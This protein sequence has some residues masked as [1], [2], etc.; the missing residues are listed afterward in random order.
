MRRLY[1]KG[2]RNPL[3]AQRKEGARD[4]TQQTYIMITLSVTLP[5]LILYAQ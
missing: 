5:L 1:I 3:C 2:L 4:A